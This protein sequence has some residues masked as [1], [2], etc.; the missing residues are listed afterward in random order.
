MEWNAAD[1]SRREGRGEERG[2]RR[3]ERSSVPLVCSQ[4]PL[5]VRKVAT[6]AVAVITGCGGAWLVLTSPLHCSP[7]RV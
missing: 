4:G 2:M 7:P 3:G 6:A 5:A 1:V